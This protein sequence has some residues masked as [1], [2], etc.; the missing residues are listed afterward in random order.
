MDAYIQAAEAVFEENGPAC[1]EIDHAGGNPVHYAKLFSPRKNTDNSTCWG[2][3]WC[4]KRAGS[5]MKD[6]DSRIVKNC[7]VLALCFMSA[8]VKAGD[9]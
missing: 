2:W 9:A 5:V 7:R 6:E 3:A 1:L 4:G 8:I